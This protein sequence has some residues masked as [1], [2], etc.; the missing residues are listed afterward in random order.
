[1]IEG[2]K[3]KLSPILADEQGAWGIVERLPRTINIS[4]FRIDVL[5]RVLTFLKTLQIREVD[6]GCLQLEGSKKALVLRPN[7]ENEEAD[8]YTRGVVVVMPVSFEE[9]EE[10]A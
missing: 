1:M 2:K 4:T 6:I 10:D 7:Y 5:E 9:D 3:V 8:K